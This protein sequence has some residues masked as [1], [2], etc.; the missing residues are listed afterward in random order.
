MTGCLPAEHVLLRQSSTNMQYPRPNMSASPIQINA[1]LVSS[2]AEVKRAI[3][4]PSR[5]KTCAML[6]RM[7]VSCIKHH[8]IHD[9][10]EGCPQ[11]ALPAKQLT[12]KELTGEQDCATSCA[13]LIEYQPGFIDL[14]SWLEGVYGKTFAQIERDAHRA[15]TEADMRGI[16][17]RDL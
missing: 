13:G 14:V 4:T 5:D 6:P 1:L 12:L 15:M 11:C 17:Y 9:L 10:L 2:T 7:E 16:A 3:Y 8:V